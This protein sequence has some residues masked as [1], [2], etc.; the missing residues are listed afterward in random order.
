M[1]KLIILIEVVFLVIGC[2]DSAN[3]PVQQI[4]SINPKSE[5][6]TIS[7]DNTYDYLSRERI[8]PSNIQE[9]KSRLK[10]LNIRVEKVEEY[11]KEKMETV[12]YEKYEPIKNIMVEDRERFRKM[13]EDA[14][15]ANHLAYNHKNIMKLF[16]AVRKE[17]F[18]NTGKLLYQ[19]DFDIFINNILIRTHLSPVTPEHFSYFINDFKNGDL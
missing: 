14:I 12:F 5:G 19:A 16:P 10:R 6:H 13:I 1:K 11:G 9:L 17:D 2:N 7:S 8:K 18:K 3:S 4:S 15:N